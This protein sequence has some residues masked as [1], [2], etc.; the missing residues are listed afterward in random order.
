MCGFKKASLRTS[1]LCRC[2]VAIAEPDLIHREYCVRNDVMCFIR[3]SSATA[4][5]QRN[6]AISLSSSTTSLSAVQTGLCREESQCSPPQYGAA[7]MPPESFWPRSEARNFL[8]E[9]MYVRPSVRPSVCLSVCLS[10]ARLNGSRYRNTLHTCP[11]G[12][13]VGWY[14]TLGP[15]R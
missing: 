2:V 9:C 14:S 10:D 5:P 12:P 1:H 7:D 6:Y 8:S 3:S 13:P 11:P 4:S 15:P